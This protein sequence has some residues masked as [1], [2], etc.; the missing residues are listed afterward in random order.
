MIRRILDPLIINAFSAH[1]DIA[2]E[3]GG[4]LDFTNAMDG[5][6][7][8]FGEHGGFCFEQTGPA[9]FEVH[10]MI[11]KAGRGTW[12]F[13]AA[14]ETL[15]MIEALGARRLWARVGTKKLA[16]FTHK[17]GFREVGEMPPYRIFEWRSECPL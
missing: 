4:A 14:K 6:I 5:K 3:I 17:A 10:V 16:Y 15:A 12:G 11:T 1:P 8:L 13:R 9:E 2:P 7:Y